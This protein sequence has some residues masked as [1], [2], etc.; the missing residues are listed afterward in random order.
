MK[1]K[2]TLLIISMFLLAACGA[3]RTVSESNPKLDS[4]IQN[5]GF[6]IEMNSMQPLPTRALNQIAN[7]GLIQPGNT[8]NRIDLTSANHFVRMQRDSVSSNLPYF[9]ERQMGGG[10]NNKTGIEFDGVPRE[11]EVTKNERDNSYDVNFTINESSETFFVRLKLFPNLSVWADIWSS[12]R[13]R[14][15]YS[16]NV[17]AL[18]D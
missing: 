6:K 7:S 4:M 15:R 3:S 13:N 10:Y 12:H 11:I 2:T 1:Y 9:G 16:G 5:L 18:E 17:V 14:I 8:I